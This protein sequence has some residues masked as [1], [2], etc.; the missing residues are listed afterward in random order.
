[1]DRFVQYRMTVIWSNLIH[2]LENKITILHINMW[3]MQIRSIDDLIVIKQNIKIEGA[4][5]PVDQTVTVG[6]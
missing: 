1:M 2:R 3:N 4:R 5:S 6:F